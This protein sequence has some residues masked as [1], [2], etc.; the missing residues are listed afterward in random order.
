MRILKTGDRNFPR[1]FKGIVTR[2]ATAAEEVETTVRSILQDVK[3]GGD[4]ALIRLTEK[5]DNNKIT[6]KNLRIAERD[7]KKSPQKIPAADLSSL[8]RACGRIEAFHCRQLQQSWISADT[9]GEIIGQLVRPLERVG[10]YVPGGKAVYPSSVLMNAIPARVAGVAE[11]IMV[12]PGS[13][14]GINPVL[15]AAADLCGI[16]SVFQIGGAQ[17]IAALAYGTAS[18]P[19]VD[20]IV[21]PGNIYVATAKKL[22][23][24]DVDIDMIAGPSEILIISDGSGSPACAAADMLSQAE[25]DEMACS[26][27]VTTDEVFARRVANELTAQ[28]KKLKRRAIAGRSLE[29]HG[30]I[31]ITR[32]IAEAVQLANDVAPEHLELAVANPWDLLPQIKNAG[33]VFLGHYSPEALGDYLAGPNHVLPTGGTAR[34]FS[35]LSVDD[36]LKKTSLISFTREALQAV[37]Q[38]VI[39]IADAEH[40]DAHASSVKVR[41]KK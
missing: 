31:I 6:V 18:V 9:P 24:G 35:P 19:K 29:N 1:L 2:G 16:R 7:I 34:F 4:A 17:A 10:I 41:L 27:L 25:H 26:I 37:G 20:K 14:K 3:T 8:T 22:V 40:L 39:R 36:F 13:G 30:A 21:G 23:Y 32:T 28:I 38:D 11:I 12:T 5:Y 15:L 33:A